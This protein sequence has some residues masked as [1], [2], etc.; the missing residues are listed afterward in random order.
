MKI[1][2][3]LV[4]YLLK[5]KKL[6]LQGIG[7]FELDAS[8]PDSADPDRPIILPENSVTFYYD[9]KVTEDE[10]LVDFIVEHTNKIKPLA[11]SDLDSFLSLGRQFLNIGKPFTLPNIGTLEKLNSGVLAFKPGQLIA[12]KIE[13]N[14]VRNEETNGEA[15]EESLFNDY[16]KDRKSKNG[17]KAIFVLLILIILGFIGWA[18]W[19]YGFNQKNEPDTLTTTEPVVPIHDSAYRADSAI[20]ANAAT[21]SIKRASDSVNFLIVISRYKN[22]SAAEWK[23]KT[24]KKNLPD[25]QIY[26]TDSV[27]YKVVQ[28][29]KLPLSDTT[30]ILDSMKVIYPKALVQLK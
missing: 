27:V 5:N 26:T 2:Q 24:V 8:L 25:A 15:P 30:R 11:A 10:G 1:E 12:Q 21:D 18:V 17:A 6:T 19:H 3:V 4:H 29:F 14:K 13:P 20:I 16:Q 22:L 9:P 23:V 7:T 28:P